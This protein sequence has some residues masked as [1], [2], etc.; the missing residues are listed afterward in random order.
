MKSFFEKAIITFLAVIILTLLGFE[1]DNLKKGDN[2][3]Y[4]TTLESKADSLLSLMTLDEKIGQMTQVDILALKSFKDI[5]KYSLGSIL[6]GGNSE[7]KDETASGWANY[8]DSL[9]SYALKSRLKIPIIYGVDAVHGHNNVLGAV[10][11]PHNIGIGCTR[12]PKLAEEEGHVTASEITGTG[13]N[14]DFAPCIAVA[15]NERWG[16]TY[17][18][19][20]E[21]PQLVSEMGR[22]FIKGLQDAKFNSHLSVIACAKH[23][24]GDGGTTNGKDQG[25][26]QC[27]EKTLRKIHMPGYIAAVK[28][29]VQTIMVSYS[30]WNGVKMHGN[31]Y[32]LTDV[33][34]K[35][36]GFKGFLVSDWAAIDQ[37]GNDYKNDIE[38]SI[39]AGLDMIMIPNGPGTRNNYV[40]FINDLKDLVNSGAVPM[41]RINDAVKR[42]LRVK[43]EIGVFQQPFTDKEYT[44]TVGSKAHR[45]IARQCVRESMVLLK[46]SDNIL[47]LSKSIKHIVVAGKNADNLGY[48]CGGWT[49]SWQGDSGN[50]TSGGTTIFQAVKQAV[51]PD[52]K[53]TLSKDGS[54]VD[55]ADVAIV[56]VGEKPYAEMIGD[57]KN[58][59]LSKEDESVIDN[60]K[61]KGI[62][63]VVILISGRPMIINS[64]LKKC[65]AFIAAWLPGTE[66]EGI[67]DVLFGDYKPTGKLSHSWPRSMKQIPINV[68]DKNYNPLFPYGFGLTYKNK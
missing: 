16:R 7:I 2:R 18:S 40:E 8:Y 5:S 23:F 29:G 17:E 47:P 19:Y 57:R 30:S 53:V 9:Q 22:A 56:C 21:N 13:M 25:N 49:I 48:Q 58:L 28:A 15:R 44:S 37:L 61:S 52:T 11:F 10:I 6:C 27:D 14:W 65:D 1:N 41:S 24:V 31:K 12:D 4:N 3:N 62:P 34:K 59:A 33:L 68:G 55:K 20:G 51:S 38:K 54:D 45:E 39:N 63:V 26:T 46:N 35:E 36:L 64:A 43:L 50:V 67:T 42:I 60:F 66:G 32:L